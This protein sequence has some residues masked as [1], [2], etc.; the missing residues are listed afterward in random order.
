MTQSSEKSDRLATLPAETVRSRPST[1]A[2]TRAWWQQ[3]YPWLVLLGGLVVLNL[4]H[5]FPQYLSL[6]PTRSRSVLDEGF[7]AHYPL[8]L[9]HIVTGN[10]AMLTVFLQ[11]WPWLR[12]TQPAVHRLSGRV[13]ILAGALPSALIG[14]FFLVPHRPGSGGSLGLAVSAVLWVGTTLMAWRKARQGRYAEHR[15]WMIY[16]F[17]LAMHTTYGRIV[18]LMFMTI[19]GFS[20]NEAILIESTN[21]LSWVLNLLVAQWWLE[22]TAKKTSRQNHQLVGY[23]L[24]R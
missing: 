17:A 19:P 4:L 9:V 3:P 23:A 10:I 13:Y 12:R 8:L 20:V 7:N 24:P 11:L 16:S 6:D 14:L 15:R 22:R 2:P 1:A 18:F 5:A 21:W